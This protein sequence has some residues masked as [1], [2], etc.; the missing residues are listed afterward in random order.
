MMERSSEIQTIS[1]E[2]FRTAKAIRLLRI[3]FQAEERSILA[4]VSYARKTPDGWVKSPILRVID[5]DKR[6]FI[7]DYPGDK[8]STRYFKRIAP[9]IVSYLGSVLK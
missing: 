4:G 2:H 7:D 8:G 1:L 6:R 3:E 5:L 9:R